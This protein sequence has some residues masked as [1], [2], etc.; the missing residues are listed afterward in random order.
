ASSFLVSPF[1]SAALA[2]VDGFEDFVS[3]M[4][5]LG[6]G[7]KVTV[8]DRVTFPH[9]LGL[10]YL[11]MTQYLR[12]LDYGDEYKVMGLAAYGKPEDLNAMRQAVRLKPNGKLELEMSYMLHIVVG[13][14]MT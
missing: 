9:S 6:E 12:F 13:V 8:F 1:E 3:T 4:V 11:A 2:S 7:V 10:F 5:G 14:R